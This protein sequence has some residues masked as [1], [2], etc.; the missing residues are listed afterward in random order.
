MRIGKFS[1]NSSDFWKTV[2]WSAVSAAAAFLAYFGAN[3]SG[4]DSVWGPLLSTA[5]IAA[6]KAI[7]RLLTPSDPTPQG[8]K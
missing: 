4:V 1:F 3:I 2:E 8:E 7:Q 6:A 5:A